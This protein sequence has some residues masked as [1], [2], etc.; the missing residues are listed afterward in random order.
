MNKYFDKNDI[1]FFKILGATGLVI[2][3]LAWALI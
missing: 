1:N 3:T 2:L